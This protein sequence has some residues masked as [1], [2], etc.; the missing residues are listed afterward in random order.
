MQT[1][2]N[3]ISNIDTI[4]KKHD[5]K[6]L[7]VICP[8]LPSIR[9][10]IENIPVKTVIFNDFTSNPRYE[11]ILNAIDLYKNSNCDSL[12]AIGGGSAIDIAKCVK[13]F[14][15][16][17]RE[18]HFNTE[19]YADNLIPFIAIPTTAGTGSE[20][21]QYSIIY[22]NNEK[23][24]VTHESIIPGFIIFIPDLLNSLPLYQKKC[25]FLDALCQAI[26]SWWCIKS[27]QESIF[28]SK[29]AIEILL[30]NYKHYLMDFDNEVNYNMLLGSNYAGKAINITQTTAPHALSYKLTS[31]Y[32]L[33][34]GHAVAIGFPVVWQYMLE[35]IEKTSDSRGAKYLCDTFNDISIALGYKNPS[36]AIS[37]FNDLLHDLEII[38][39]E[40]ADKNI[41]PDLVS[42]VNIQKLNNTPVA[43]NQENIYQIYKNILLK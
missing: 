38:S 5:I 30:K 41:I 29:K 3:N 12:M 8:Q 43:F 42:S 14:M 28:F 10:L 21:T 23:H 19:K 36:E 34:H 35:N 15:R 39:P 7:F 11:E 6:N 20:S 4:L 33:P 31:N 27:T 13:L 16:M 22:V 9:S 37:G 24:T 40:N 26:E 2:F 25:T 18:D 32:K 1:I 17:D